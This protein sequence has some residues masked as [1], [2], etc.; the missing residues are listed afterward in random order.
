MTARRFFTH[1]FGI[2][3]AAIVATFLWGSAFPFIKLSYEQLQIESHEIGEQ[4]V[5]AGYRFFLSACMIFIFFRLLGQKMTCRKETI[6]TLLSLAT[7]QTFLQYVLF[8]IGMSYSTGIQGSIIA[9]TTSFFQLLLAHFMYKDDSFSLRKG[10]GI[11]I[12]FSG[13]IVV[14]MTKGVLQ[15]D[16]GIGEWLL[17]AAMFVSAY[18]NI[19]ARNASM[20]MEIGYLTAYQMLFGSLGLFII[21]SFS[22]GMFPFTFTSTTIAML[23]YLSFLSAAGFVLW[24]NVMKYNKVGNV[25]M[26]L[27]LIPVFGVFLS[28]MILNESL[29]MF[30]LIGLALV[31]AGIIIVNRARPSV[32][33]DNS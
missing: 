8:Y 18:G 28:S 23:V 26:Y 11:I 20:K 12:G 24:N 16:F 27:F 31:T 3:A 2:L 9:G 4:L 33:K 14:N 13:V 7:F 15:I 22:A 19:L 17:I 29:H 25:S 5:F 10:I 6:P 1:P 30:V 21:G 32:Q